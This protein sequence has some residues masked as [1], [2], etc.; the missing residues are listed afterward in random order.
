MLDYKRPYPNWLIED[1]RDTIEDLDISEDTTKEELLSRVQHLRQE[2][3]WA[4]EECNTK[5]MQAEY[6]EFIALN[7]GVKEFLDKNMGE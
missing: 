6:L 1:L 3:H 7:G 5:E 4:Y 2:A